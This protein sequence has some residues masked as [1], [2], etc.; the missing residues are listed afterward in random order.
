MALNTVSL[1][2]CEQH[3]DDAS[4]LWPY[5]D[6][7]VKSPN[8]TF[9]ELAELD[10]RLEAH[11]ESLKN[12]QENTKT[13]VK[14]A[15]EKITSNASPYTI[16]LSCHVLGRSYRS[17]GICDFLLNA[18]IE[19]F[20]RNCVLAERS[21]SYFLMKVILG[22]PAGDEFIAATYD[23][24]I[25]N[26]LAAGDQKRLQFISIYTPA[27][28]IDGLD[29]EADYHFSLFVRA[30]RAE[31]DAVQKRHLDKLVSLGTDGKPYITLCKGLYER[32][33]ITFVEGLSDFLAHYQREGESGNLP[34]E[35]DGYLS[36]KGIGV[37]RLAGMKGMKFE[38]DHA[39]IPRELIEDGPCPE[40]TEGFP[41]LTDDEI[42]KFKNILMSLKK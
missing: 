23:D 2:I 41:R 30:F 19:S 40:V 7:A 36:V 28:Y 11:L 31:D 9:H 33:E 6:Q 26:S 20:R 21:R 37:C 16:Q 22:M 27:K 5:R 34:S 4:F 15:L 32:N 42:E 29:E 24:H 8:Y 17:L 35:T 13:T 3:V 14:T 18:D 10:E 1:E 12:I 39:L 25:Y 38:F